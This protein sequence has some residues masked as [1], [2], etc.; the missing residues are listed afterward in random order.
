MTK[1]ILLAAT[2]LSAIALAGAANA[3]VVTTS[4]ISGVS[5]TPVSVVGT[6]ATAQTGPTALYSLANESV[7]SATTRSTTSSTQTTATYIGTSGGTGAG[8]ASLPGVAGGRY[9]VTFTLAG[10]AAPTFSSSLAP[11]SL[12]VASGGAC[13]AAVSAPVLVAG[14]ARGDSSVSYEFDAGAACTGAAGLGITAVTLLHPFEVAQFGAVN[15][16]VLTESIGASTAGLYTA[17]TGGS[18]AQQI[19]GAALRTGVP[20]VAQVVGYEFVPNST[21]ASNFGGVDQ[22]NLAPNAAGNRFATI[23]GDG[24]GTVGFQRVDLNGATAGTPVAH[25]GLRGSEIPAESYTL[26]VFARSGVFGTA[27]TNG[28]AASIGGT[29]GTRQAN[30]AQSR[31]TTLTGTQVIA[32][33]AANPASTDALASADQTFEAVVTPGTSTLVN[34]PAARTFTLQNVVLEGTSILAP[35]MT[36]NAANANTV[37]RLANSSTTAVGAV[38]LDLRAPLANTATS[39]RTCTAAV[40]AGLAGIPAGG[41]LVINSAMLQRCFGDFTRGDV[42]VRV[43]DTNTSGISAKLRAVTAG[44]VVTEQSLGRGSGTTTIQ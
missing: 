19:G 18:L 14:G 29:V 37:L 25:A 23:T 16:T 10:A 31:R 7:S 24:V 28:I 20:I 33:Q 35:W 41:E 36:S 8:L 3:Q 32:I 2:A 26:D 15:V 13:T 12:T 39:A 42:Q 44:G 40:E 11:A 9:R 21:L 5:A 34:L 43:L 17:V 30:T 27:A 38:Q 22:F 4:T 6:T 1:N